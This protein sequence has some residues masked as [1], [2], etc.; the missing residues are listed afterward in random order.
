MTSDLIRDRLPDPRVP[1]CADHCSFAEASGARE[2]FCV[3]ACYMLTVCSTC[4]HQEIVHGGFARPDGSC[5]Y[6]G[7]DCRRYAP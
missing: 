4:Q 6:R 3:S 2:Y 1:D 7:C 5:A